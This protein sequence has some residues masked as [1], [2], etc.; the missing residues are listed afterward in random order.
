MGL[1]TGPG[2]DLL[3]SQGR[4]LRWVAAHQ[5]VD[6]LLEEAVKVAQAKEADEADGEDV[7]CR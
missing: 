7:R 3:F 5:M 6:A 2:R 1:A 4:Q